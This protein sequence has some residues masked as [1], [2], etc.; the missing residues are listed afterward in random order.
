[1][2]PDQPDSKK[3]LVKF[4]RTY[5]R[6]VHEHLAS[7]KFAPELLGFNELRGGWKMIVMEYLEAPLW[8][9]GSTL[10]V[11]DQAVLQKL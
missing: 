3:L 1:M 2:Q 7:H 4:T 11:L 6:D 9:D 8:Q 5:G 10:S